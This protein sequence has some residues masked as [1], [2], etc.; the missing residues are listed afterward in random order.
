MF[1]RL[2]QL[3]S[4]IPLQLLVPL[5]LWVSGPMQAETASFQADLHEANWTPQTSVFACSLK[6]SIPDFGEVEFQHRAG[7]TLRFRVM[8]FSPLLADDNIVLRVLPAPW[9]YQQQARELARLSPP[10]ASGLQLEE[11]LARQ[12][13]AEMLDGMVPTVQ[14]FARYDARQSLSIAV[15]PLHF[16]AAY[17]DYQMCTGSLLPVNYEQIGRSTIFFPSGARELNDSARR[18]L[19]NI[20]RYANADERVIGFEVDSFTDTVGERR[21]NLLVAEYRAMRVTE[22]LIIQGIDPESIATRAHGE[23]EEYLIVNPERTAAD[24]DRNRRV[25]IVMLRR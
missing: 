21:A 24:R 4:S 12:L 19:D 1:F 10:Q 5:M 23:R 14:G 11:T 13:M 7:E 8:P 22:Y 17:R 6:Q 2:C 16:Q 15:S 20:V 9:N 3:P 25:N 18:L